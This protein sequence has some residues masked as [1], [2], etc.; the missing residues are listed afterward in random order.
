MEVEEEVAVEEDAVEAELAV[1]V[2]PIDRFGLKPC[3]CDPPPQLSSTA[4]P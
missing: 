1:V 4:M 3:R 2:A